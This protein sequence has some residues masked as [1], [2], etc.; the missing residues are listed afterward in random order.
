[1][2]HPDMPLRQVTVRHPAATLGVEG[3]SYQFPGETFRVLI[4]NPPPNRSALCTMYSNGL[5]AMGPRSADES[6]HVKCASV[7]EAQAYVQA[8]I[9]LG[10]L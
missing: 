10:E 2:N 6:Q 7:A 4:G 5:V 9:D 8:L 3:N 1:M